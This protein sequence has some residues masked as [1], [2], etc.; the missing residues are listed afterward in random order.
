M[1]SKL[2]NI[3]VIG[4]S[5]SEPIATDLNQSVGNIC[6]RS[7]ELQPIGSEEAS[8]KPDLHS[9]RGVSLEDLGSEL[10]DRSSL[11]ILVEGVLGTGKTTL[12]PFLIDRYCLERYLTILCFHLTSKVCK[13]IR[14]LTDVAEELSLPVLQ[15]KSQLEDGGSDSLIIIDGITELTQRNDWESSVFAKILFGKEFPNATKLLLTRPSGVVHVLEHVTLDHF[16]RLEGLQ[17]P[18]LMLLSKPENDCINK[19]C[20]QHPELVTM[21]KIPLM[22]KIILG[23]LNTKHDNLTITDVCLHTITELIKR[24]LKQLSYQIDDNLTLF[25]LPVEIA[26]DFLKLCKFAYHSLASS[27]LLITPEQKERFISGFS[28][29][30]S[31]FLSSNETFGLIEVVYTAGVS[32]FQ[33][34]NPLVHEFLAGYYVQ[35]LPPLDVLDVLNRHASQILSQS[36][37]YW[38]VFFFGLSWRRSLTF[39]PIKC[40]ST[41]LFEF[42]IHCI[43]RCLDKNGVFTLMLCVAETKDDQLWKK[44]ASNLG[45]SISLLLTVDKFQ[46]HMW[47]IASM[48]SCSEIRE[49]NI[50]ASN[51][52]ACRELESFDIY[53]SASLHK[54]VVHD[55]GEMISISPK[56]TIEAASRRQKEFE[57]FSESGDKEAAFMNHFQCRV[58]REIL[59]RRFKN[60]SVIKLKGD[61]SNPAYVSF[62]SCACFKTSLQDNLVFDPY[63]PYHFLEVTSKKTLKKIVDENRIHMATHDGKAIELV[64]LLKPCLRRVTIINPDTSEKDCIVFTSQELA[65]TIAMSSSVSASESTQEILDI[66]LNETVP[67]AY[68]EMVRPALPLPRSLDDNTRSSTVFPLVTTPGVLPQRPI[69]HGELEQRETHQRQRHEN[70]GSGSPTFDFPYSSQYNQHLPVASEQTQQTATATTVISSQQVVHPKSS[71]KPGAILYTSKPYQFPSDHIHPLPDESHQVRRGGNG[72]IFSGTIGGVSVVYKKTNYRSREFAIITKL[73]HNNIV[74]LF[75]FMY[76]AEN[77]SH[78][79]RHFCYH[80]MPQLS[81]DCARMLTDKKDLT[82]K[83]LHKKHGDNPRKI[84]VIRGNLKYLLKEVLQGLRYLHSLRIAHRDVKGSNIL[85]KFDCVCTNPL[86]CGCDTKYQVQICDFD[87][88]I[89]LDT[90]ERIPCT[91]SSSSRMQYVCVPVGTN[92]FRSPECSM[93]VVSNSSD[94]FSPPINTRC[95]IWSLGILTIRMLIGATGPSSQR[96]MALLL[97]YYHRQRYMHEGL[98]K[99]GYLEVDRIVTDKL[100]NVS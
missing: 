17:D 89:E 31:F 60:C 55:M 92:G 56:M 21:C 54:T 9:E 51:F 12:V 32:L 1:T 83:E 100:L 69:V 84:G 71:I 39:D 26:D 61:A 81:G 57:Q 40:M 77:P 65:H 76:G 38:L 22:A 18:S 7:V 3:L 72:Q 11:N 10:N 20:Q 13:E 23:Q 44:L 46:M 48:L 45:G 36:S 37:S 8:V 50:N 78:K 47:T 98:H 63:V 49:W 67:D 42:L 99:G 90:N 75:A 14:T 88:A 53:S 95:D 64:I 58:I 19:L 93:L 73:K 87:A 33:F 4:R 70:V 15:L 41:T 29:S 86:E 27:H 43:T 94:T 97:L 34:I 82:I 80:I 5:N 52:H 62:L 85:L 68:S 16:F 79:R 24:R 74:R 28:L 91:S 30:N 66:I 2:G 59:Q 96:E 25:S 6:L 35:S